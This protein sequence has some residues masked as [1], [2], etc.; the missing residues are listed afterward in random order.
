MQ[1]RETKAKE[2]K[3]TEDK[4]MQV[5]KRERGELRWDINKKKRRGTK[6]TKIKG[7]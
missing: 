6:R 5:L 4:E 7:A 1:K 3:R 2:N